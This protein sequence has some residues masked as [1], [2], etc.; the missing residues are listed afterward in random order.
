MRFC[1]L[2]LC[3][4]VWVVETN[5]AFEKSETVFAIIAPK[6]KWLSFENSLSVI[7]RFTTSIPL[8]C[9]N[10][11]NASM[12]T[13][14]RFLTHVYLLDSLK[15]SLRCRR[16]IVSFIL[17][18]VQ[19][20]ILSM[21]SLSKYKWKVSSMFSILFALEFGARQLIPP[22]MVSDFRC[23]PVATGCSELHQIFFVF[24]SYFG[25]R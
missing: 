7:R 3:S 17:V 6:T 20:I 24:S 25:P 9:I 19:S 22:E 12:S 16:A 14:S 18:F 1:F 10:P 13:L 15:L 8:K 5:V 4:F 21:I 11:S 2:Q 23:L